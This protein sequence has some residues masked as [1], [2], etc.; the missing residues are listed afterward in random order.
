MNTDTY[1]GSLSFTMLRQVIRGRSLNPDTD[2][3][4]QSMYETSNLKILSMS[5]H[6]IIRA[7]HRDTSFLSLGVDRLQKK[8]IAQ[9]NSVVTRD[10]YEIGFNPVLTADDFEALKSGNLPADISTEQKYISEARYLWVIFPIWWTSMP[11]ILKGYIDRVMLSGFAYRMKDDAPVGLLT[12]KKVIL[13]NSMGM[14]REE[15]RKTG[16]FDAL[17]LTIDRGVFEFT[18]M[19]VIAHKYFT[20]IMSADD[21][22]RENYYNE[23]AELADKIHKEQKRDNSGKSRKVA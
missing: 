18:G 12:D 21:E 10:L 5:R 23:L 15:Y 2:Y 22:L 6:L 14:S 11:A 17:K 3:L 19:T 9:G 13:L 20:S 8:L 7:L 16:M 1:G 4:G